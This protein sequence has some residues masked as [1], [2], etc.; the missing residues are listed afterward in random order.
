MLKVEIYK[1]IK[2]ASGGDAIT[3]DAEFSKGKIT[4]IY[5]NSGE[6]KTTIFNSITGLVT[7]EK[8]C[9]TFNDK[10]W[11]NSV[12]KTDVL[13]RHRNIGYLF[14]EDS[15][16]PHFTVKQNILY[17][18]SKAEQKKLDLKEVLEQVEMNGFEDSYPQNLSGGQKQ[19][20]AIARALA[21][22]SELLLLDEPFSALD[23]EIKQKLYKLIRAFK[24]QFNLTILLVT[25]D[26]TDIFALC[27]E[28]LW[29]RNH[30]ANGTITK[31]AFE[32]QIKQ[33][34]A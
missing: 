31:K 12:D 15:L 3:V 24:E 18:L 16:F 22:K 11:F 2:S 8:G 33:L 9:I 30:A 14:Q 32:S 29:L 19:R 21:K 23:L 17:P 4:A 27:D 7:P 13:I 10:T 20:I 6:G 26:I 25:H 5:G 34:S 28:V 1:E